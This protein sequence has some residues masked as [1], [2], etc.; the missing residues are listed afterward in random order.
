MSN[1]YFD[2]DYEV[3]DV[4]LDA[5]GAAIEEADD[6]W[7][8]YAYLSV[9]KMACPECGGAG[10]IGGGS[11][12]SLCPGC[13]GARVVDHPGAEA[14]AIPDFSPMRRALRNYTIAMADRALPDGH[15]AKRGLALP[16]ASTLPRPEAIRDLAKRIKQESKQ[17]SGTPNLQLAEPKEEAMGSLGSGDAEF[18]DDDLDECIDEDTSRR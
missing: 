13:L 2:D 11:L 8:K 3:T 4:D 1:E 9:P 7:Q 12:G 14:P 16:P 15:R 6:L 5:I 10:S 18:T 17:L